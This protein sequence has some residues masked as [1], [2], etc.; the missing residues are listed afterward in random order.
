MPTV[1]VKGMR[2]EHCRKA[3]TEAVAKVSGVSG[4]QVDLQLGLLSW[5]NAGPDDLATKEVKK[6]VKGIGFE[7]E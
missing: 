4:V 5:Q 1:T 7:V 6:A 2:C 3:V